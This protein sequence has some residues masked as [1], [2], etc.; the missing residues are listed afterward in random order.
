M[1][2]EQFQTGLALLSGQV[3]TAWRTRLGHLLERIHAVYE[4][5]PR[6]FRLLPPEQ[7]NRLLFQELRV[8]G[9][10][11]SAAQGAARG[12][13]DAFF[14]GDI[15]GTVA[16]L[17]DEIWAVWP[18]GRIG[19]HLSVDLG[20]GLVPRGEDLGSGFKTTHWKVYGYGEFNQ[21]LLAGLA[22]LYDAVLGLRSVV[23][24]T[25]RLTS[26]DAAPVRILLAMV[27]DEGGRWRS[28]NLPMIAPDD[29]IHASV[30]LGQ[31]EDDRLKMV[32]RFV[33][34][35][36]LGQTAQLKSAASALAE[37]VFVKRSLALQELCEAIEAQQ[38][39]RGSTETTFLGSRLGSYD[40]FKKS[41]VRGEREA[42]ENS[43]QTFESRS[44]DELEPRVVHT[45]VGR[46]EPRSDK[47]HHETEFT[48]MLF[49]YEDRQKEVE[50]HKIAALFL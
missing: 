49:R 44:L 31:Y 2:S 45:S 3:S 37:R 24:V 27:R 30:R 22:P 12:L 26:P 4:V 42:F 43:I 36:V 29:A 17:S 6:E 28:K 21:A 47:S 13:V 34:A 11:R 5:N 10:E 41:L 1:T 14:S 35:V 20:K 46:F 50:H 16:G 19:K 38:L 23:T 32:E 8:L 40:H 39:F 48:S 18:N 9:Q 33:R 15:S 25:A 7:N